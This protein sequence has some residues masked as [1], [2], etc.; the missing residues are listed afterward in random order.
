MTVVAFL[1]I[2]DALILF[3]KFRA[4]VSTVLK[5]LWGIEFRRKTLTSPFAFEAKIAEAVFQ[6]LSGTAKDFTNNFE[7]LSTHWILQ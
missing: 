1:P 4:C 5:T 3:T 2:T 6:M 7:Q